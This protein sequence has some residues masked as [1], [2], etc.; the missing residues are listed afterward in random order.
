MKK[1]HCILNLVICIIASINFSKAQDI[2][3][4]FDSITKEI[5][6]SEIV[7]VDSATKEE[8]FYRARTWFV[9]TYADAKNVIQIQDKESGEIVG[10]GSS[11]IPFMISYILLNH[12]IYI[13][14]KDGRY[15]YIITELTTT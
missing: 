2:N 9:K 10:K 8:L 13:Y 3:L 4:P 7:K 11:K 14:A 5:T 1:K 12:A 15:K 6:Y